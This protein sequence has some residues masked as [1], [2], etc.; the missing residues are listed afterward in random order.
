M[1]I[2]YGGQGETHELAIADEVKWKS[3]GPPVQVKTVKKGA[4][5]SFTAVQW[6]TSPERRIFKAG[7]LHIYILGWFYLDCNSSKRHIANR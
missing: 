7:N 2:V 6:K 5:K 1:L 3:T 4:K